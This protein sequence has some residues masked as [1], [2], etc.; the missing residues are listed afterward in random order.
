MTN[1]ASLV[2]L[3]IFLLIALCA[4]CIARSRSR[5]EQGQNF[6]KSYFIGSRGLGGFVLAMTCIAT[7]GSVS[8]FVGGPGMA[9]KIGF[10]W[11]YMAA[12]QVTSLI[13]LY[14]ILG[15]KMALIGRRLGAVTVV[16]VIHK[17]YNSPALAYLSALVIVVFFVA[18]MVAQFVGGAKLLEA[19]TGFSYV[20]GLLLFGLVSILFTAIGGFR[21]V[22]LTDALCGIMMLVGIGFL[23]F[24]IFDQG[25]GF[26]AVMDTLQLTR[27]EF[28]D[29]FS[30]GKM[31]ASLYVSQWLL[32]GMLTLCLP[33][34]VVR[35]L[36]FKDTKS[37]HSALVMGT[38]ILGAM[39][40]GITSLG[41]CAAAVMPEALDAYGP[42]IDSIIPY[43]LSHLLPSWAVGIAL[44]GPLAA[45]I[46]TVSSL[47]ISASSA[48]VNDMYLLHCAQRQRRASDKFV[49]I[50]SQL[51]TLLVGIVVCALAI[52][53]PELIWKINMF[54]FGGLETAF[55]C[56]LLC[57]LFWKRASTIG[58]ISSMGLGVIAYCSS[59]LIGFKPFGLHQIVIGLVVAGL[60]MLFGSLAF[61]QKNCSHQDIFFPKPDS[62]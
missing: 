18:T 45:S 60:A 4:A 36:S 21:G 42:T 61:P 22:A 58:A 13:L 50:T 43:A 59:M 11:V 25:G 40:I 28:F 24:G 32:V 37:L 20:Q 6:V 47:L 7:Y 39:M 8:S 41:V 54:A 16:D 2:P 34:S 10:G 15:K 26:I 19:V 30:D 33:Q 14:G 48:L 38:I 29:P 46:S 35:T 53:P 3:G 23:A 51:A 55:S 49:R 17:R 1:L 56:V 44:V 52:V 5:S 62:L 57:G 27:P 9:W 31:P 12:V